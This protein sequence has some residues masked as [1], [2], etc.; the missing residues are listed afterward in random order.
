[1]H[2]KIHPFL[3]SRS[4]EQVTGL[5]G[6]KISYTL[7]GRGGNIDVNLLCNQTAPHDTNINF[8]VDGLIGEIFTVSGYSYY[9][10]NS[11]F[12]P[13]IYNLL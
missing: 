9:G 6:L 5:P 3:L 12:F 13:Q 10:K 1:M 2:F 11:P 7:D 4:L 8:F